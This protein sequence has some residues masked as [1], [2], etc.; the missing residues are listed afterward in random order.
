MN[1]S[2]LTC[3]IISRP[4]YYKKPRPEIETLTKSEMQDLIA[5]LASKVS[6]IPKKKDKERRT[7]N[8][9][10][11]DI[12]RSESDL[13][14][15]IFIFGNGRIIY[16]N[17]KACSITGYDPNELA[18]FSKE[19]ILGIVHPDGRK[20]LKK[21]LVKSTNR[22]S[23]DETHELR[24]VCK[25]GAVVWLRCRTKLIDRNSS[26]AFLFAFIDIT[27]S[28]LASEELSYQKYLLEQI[29][30]I[31][32]LN[33]FITDCERMEKIWS[34][35]NILEDLGYGKKKIK[36]IEQEKYKGIF[37]PDDQNEALSED[38]SEKQLI[39][40]VAEKDYRMKAADGSWH[41]IHSRSVAFKN[42]REGR[43]TQTLGIAI[44]ITGRKLTEEELVRSK[45]KFQTLFESATDSIIILKDSKIV[46][47]NKKTLEFF[48]YGREEIVSKKITDFSPPL[49]ADGNKSG[50]TLRKIM[51]EA[52]LGRPQKF[53]WAILRSDKSVFI[54]E[55]SMKYISFLNEEYV[56]LILRDITQ[57][58]VAE[59]EIAENQYLLNRITETSP[60][61]I[62]IYD[63]EEHKTI[64]SNRN[65]AY[66]LGYT[67]KNEEIKAELIEEF[68]HQDDL[69]SFK[70]KFEIFCKA[71]DDDIIENT[72]RLRSKD[73]AWRWFN[74]RE[75]VFAR[76]DNNRPTQIL[77][78]L[79]DVTIRMDALKALEESEG[80][81]R[82]LFE[83]SPIPL[84]QEDSFNMY[85]AIKKLKEEKGNDF[86]EYLVSNPDLISELFQKMKPI[87]INGAACRLFGARDKEDLLS[88]RSGLDFI[89]TPIS[90]IQSLAKLEEGI[91]STSAEVKMKTLKGE[92]KD[93]NISQTVLPGNKDKL[94]NLL[95]TIT[96]VT[97][98][99][100][101]DEV[102][103]RLSAVV[104]TTSDAIIITDNEGF[105][106]DVNDAT[107]NLGFGNKQE[108]I[109]TNALK[110]LVKDERRK[111]YRGI[112]EII[113]DGRLKNKEYNF[114]NGFGILV[115]V[116]VSIAVLRDA[117]ST[118]TGFAAILRDISERKRI[119]LGL[120]ES[121]QK[122]ALHIEHTPLAYI[123]W[124]VNFEV[125]NWNQAAERI[126]G[127]S[128]EEATGRHAF[129]L[130]VPKREQVGVTKIMQR[131]FD[132]GTAIPNT[133][134]NFDKEGR[135]LICEW[136]NT[137]LANAEGD[138][139]G[140]A[141]LAH[142]VTERVSAEKALIESEKRLE[143]ILEATSDGVWDYN[144]LS[145]K[146]YFSPNCYKILGYS[147]EELGYSFKNWVSLIHP[148]D[149]KLFIEEFNNHLEN[150]LNQ[151]KASYR[152]KNKSG[153]WQWILSRGKVSQWDEENLPARIL[154]THEDIS[155][156]KAAEKALVSSE[157]RFRAI[158][159][160]SPFPIAVINKGGSFEY[161]N[162]QFLIIFGYNIADIPT[163]E[164]WYRLAYPDEEYRKEVVELWKYDIGGASNKKLRARTT[165]VKTKAGKIR[166]VKFIIVPLHDDKL[167]I[168]ADDITE[169]V[170]SQQEQEKLRSRLES[171][172][173]I[174]EMVDADIETLSSHIIGEI[175]HISSSPASLFGFVDEN[176]QTLTINNL[177]ADTF[178]DIEKGMTIDYNKSEQLHFTDAL[179]QRETVYINN[180]VDYYRES[181]YTGRYPEKIRRM[182]AVPVFSH[183]K[184]VALAV[185]ANKEK[186]YTRED[187]R[188]IDAFLTNANIILERQKTEEALR[189]SEQ[190]YRTLF[191]EAPIGIFQANL[192]GHYYEV[193]N[194][195]A[196]MFEFDN[197]ELKSND[198]EEIASQ[199]LPEKK[200]SAEIIKKTLLSE[201]SLQFENTYRNKSGSQLIGNLVIKTIRDTEGAPLYFLG[202]VENITNRK[203]AEQALKESEERYRRIV[204][205]ANEGIWVL[206]S[207]GRTT[208][209]NQRMADML[210]CTLDELSSS[211]VSSFLDKEWIPLV[212]RHI[213]N[214]KIGS[215]ERSDLQ[216]R[217]KDGSPLWVMAS[218][219]AIFDD[220]EKYTGS[221]SMMTDITDRKTAEERLLN[222]K[223]LFEALSKASNT[224]LTKLD[225]NDRIKSALGI[226]GRTASLARVSI[227]EQYFDK[228]NKQFGHNRIFTWQSQSRIAKKLKD[229]FEARLLEEILKNERKL[230]HG[231]IHNMKYTAGI[232]TKE[233]FDILLVPIMI[234]GAYW[235][236]IAFCHFEAKRLSQSEEQSIYLSLA[237][238]VASTI[239]QKMIADNLNKAKEDA[240]AAN[241][242]K[243]EFIAN[244]SHEIRTPM[245]AILGFGE[246]LFNKINEKKLR[247][248]ISTII[249]S[250]NNLMALINDIL[251]LS[252]IEAGR[253]DLQENTVDMEVLLMEIK[254]IF[255]Q[256]AEE[257][258]LEFDLQIKRDV[259]KTLLLDEVRFRQIL[260]NLVG[261]AIKFTDKGS[262]N[263][264]ISK[265][266][267]RKNQLTLV[268]KVEDTGIGI[269][270][271][272]QQ[273]IFQSFS[274]QSEKNGRQYSGTGL[275]LA[276][277]KR[278]SE[279]MNGKITLK[280]KQG[281]GSVFKI[282]FAG[283][284]I[285][286]SEKLPKHRVEF[287]DLDVVFEP[288][289][290]LIVDDYEYS[291][292]LIK[293]YLE[294]TNL[295]VIEAVN[296]DEALNAIQMDTPDIVLM[297]MKMPGLSG[298]EITKKIKTNEN[299]SKIPIIAFTAT[300]ITDLDKDTIEL[301]EG[302]LRKPISKKNLFS[303]LK[304]HIR[305]S[306]PKPM[307]DKYTDVLS[308]PAIKRIMT[309]HDRKQL[310]KLISILE[311]SI[312]P[313][314]QKKS[315]I[316]IIDDIENLANIIIDYGNRFNI[317]LLINYG[318]ELNSL[319]QIYDVEKIRH[320]L[321]E[322]RT[323]IRSLKEIS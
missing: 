212:E 191:E 283:V 83:N 100:K 235:G 78:L 68:V 291:R 209:V 213:E 281:K 10:F 273:Q 286:K 145:G 125:L 242:A 98:R 27:E 310:P 158:V 156:E 12:I 6:E 111:A 28:R 170:L 219:V 317:D 131:L 25:D 274:R 46:D 250:G 132:E 322:F 71:S 302:F 124:S 129:D 86:E 37:H 34:N 254:E 279:K 19:D 173:K 246:L 21:Y 127:Y 168:I 146:I 110:Y 108:L 43:V 81:F 188:Q 195:W 133:N 149:K 41:W 73:N 289:S 48:G 26:K 140:F 102:M 148:D 233:Y 109:G 186:D 18:D 59:K 115:P 207:D 36:Q 3:D 265:K 50:I 121:R 91:Q 266:Q 164:D 123:E 8:P 40:G 256:R 316:I 153:A 74:S 303:V 154:G 33:I 155:R 20:F 150:K 320:Q 30:G 228:P 49:Q 251:D 287:E 210:L 84:V 11:D 17:E 76:N 151:F 220:K 136:Y 187:A 226:I 293:H 122:L 157:R 312:L 241:R 319:A 275:G 314:A 222:Q 67:K 15:G 208:F 306:R 130:I 137:P 139:I 217:K 238:S 161:L 52:L 179:R 39:S 178:E 29:A 5:D 236:L 223:I 229:S 205:T 214:C 172:W 152:M 224:L 112:L 162:H 183:N 297:D 196:D 299:Y 64:F 296:G 231:E 215:W 53:E 298:Y 259:P 201:H 167:Y 128:Q 118:P 22:E 31:V 323:L 270:K 182:M 305:T 23:L 253:L 1:I 204:E 262:V 300:E 2:N 32:P 309:A 239:E 311:K 301:F 56:Q 135:K 61:H 99:K 116:E 44:D 169:S 203:I 9:S 267:L 103:N 247:K 269:S 77:G 218:S 237:S 165:E 126:F 142:D 113:R 35:R 249:R 143:M 80:R 216:Y 65:L 51:S 119:E 106:I 175:K 13:L 321:N 181:L 104:K 120:S 257:K 304:K 315:E 197:R 185:L 101:A 95:L 138:I 177:S 160:Y 206:G 94:S 38:L 90:A 85:N 243:S 193:N 268:L 114:H 276:I 308:K 284:E 263:V 271:E 180:F 184:I 194:A 171:L 192:E 307:S 230:F 252:K 72:F 278:L 92:I 282:E 245:T 189:E 255:K 141:S 202:H 288:A 89:E 57:R 147:T 16:S 290:V 211:H 176:N 227:L 117:D 62:Y 294:S 198:G 47:C 54:A 42:D 107:L 7:P 285:S 69:Q 134:T 221:L 264:T 4:E 96:D 200:R 174:A 87:D 60:T 58:K 75:V 244:M 248:Y 105:I 240:E 313:A 144:L 225:F 190:K 258:Y 97:E 232:K 93:L 55:I 318:E 199:I 260:F 82:S 45:V 88:R 163:L 63:F 272:Q 159:E 234:R 261:N 277:T 24:L 14:H 292:E 280:S 79:D 166:I 70:N 66:I 295:E